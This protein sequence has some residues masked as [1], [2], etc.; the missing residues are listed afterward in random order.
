MFGKIRRMPAPVCAHPPFGHRSPDCRDRQRFIRCCDCGGVFFS[1]VDVESDAVI[2]MKP[3]MTR[4]GGRTESERKRH[5]DCDEP[6]DEPCCEPRAANRK[7]AS[8]TMRAPCASM[9]APSTFGKCGER[10]REREREREKEELGQC[11]TGF[12]VCSTSEGVSTS[13]HLVE[14]IPRN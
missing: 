13:A 6:C 14:H 8:A 12:L 10:E 1:A 3:S 9:R 5:R 7:N 2:A 11:R 4:V